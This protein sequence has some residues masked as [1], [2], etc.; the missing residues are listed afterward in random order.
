MTKGK[1][2][3][4]GNIL[5]LKLI[6]YGAGLSKKNKWCRQEKTLMLCPHRHILLLNFF[7]Y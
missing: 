1:R 4:I 2:L 7:Y 6:T 5:I 3:F